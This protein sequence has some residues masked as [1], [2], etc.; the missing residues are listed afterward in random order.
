VHRVVV[1]EVREK[2]KQLRPLGK[3]GNLALLASGP[4]RYVFVYENPE[5]REQ[6]GNV[7]KLVG[8]D[9]RGSHRLTPIV[10]NHP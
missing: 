4:A 10:L 3:A 7:S 5:L 1:Q 9:Q 8:A 2:N 6:S